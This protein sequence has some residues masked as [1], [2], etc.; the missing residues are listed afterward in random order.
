MALKV[1]LC[2]LSVF[3]VPV[4]CDESCFQRSETF[5]SKLGMEIA[6]MEKGIVEL[7]TFTKDVVWTTMQMEMRL[8]QLKM[9]MDAFRQSSM[10]AIISENVPDRMAAH[11]TASASS[12][13]QASA[14]EGSSTELSSN[15][16]MASSACSLQQLLLDQFKG[17]VL[18]EIK[19]TPVASGPVEEPM[20]IVF[21][22]NAILGVIDSCYEASKSGLY[23]IRMPGNGS[24]DVL[25][26]AEFDKGGWVVIQHRFNG[27][28]EFY[29]NWTDYEYGFGNLNGEFWLGNEKIYRLTSEKPREIAFVME[30]FDGNVGIARYDSFKLGDD[31]EKYTLKSL[32]T[33]SGSAGDSLSRNVGSMFSTY[34]MDNDKYSSSCAEVYRGGWWYDA[35]HLS[36]LNGK[37][38]KGATTVYAVSMC[39]NS[40]KGFYYSLKTSRI[41]VR[42]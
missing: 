27:S 26:D 38:M 2:L 18:I 22:K 31:T 3:F 16:S 24:M 7:S 40:F 21:E 39:W 14:G 12:M 6:V 10:S 37:Y 20:P 17:N 8:R 25:C 23:K 35:C 28:E 30:D 15:A 42:F 11:T 33:F 32:G 29:R 41:M 9:E 34:D 4:L 19:S 1:G 13:S 36:N 5:L